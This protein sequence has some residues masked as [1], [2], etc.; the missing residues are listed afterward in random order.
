MLSKYVKQLQNNTTTNKCYMPINIGSM[1]SMIINARIAHNCYLTHEQNIRKQLPVWVPDSRIGELLQNQLRHCPVWIGDQVTRFELLC[2]N[3]ND[4]YLFITHRHR[5]KEN[6]KRRA[7][8]ENPYSA[9]CAREV[10]EYSARK[11]YSDWLWVNQWLS[12]REKRWNWMV[13]KWWIG[14]REKRWPRVAI[15]RWLGKRPKRWHRV[16]AKLGF[17]DTQFPSSPFL[18]ILFEQRPF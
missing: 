3:K 15:E 16:G 10:T 9:P 12:D 13:V 17:C 18:F 11:R 8:G 5:T 7:V 1:R 4:I 14:E 2:Y 6:T